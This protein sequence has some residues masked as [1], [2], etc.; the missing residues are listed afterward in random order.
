MGTGTGSTVTAV[1][2]KTGG[3]TPPSTDS[4][5]VDEDVKK[6]KR[7]L[8]FP[9]GKRSNKNKENKGKWGGGRRRL[10]RLRRMFLIKFIAAIYC[11]RGDSYS[12]LLLYW[13]SPQFVLYSFKRF[14]SSLFG[15]LF[16][17]SLSCYVL[18]GFYFTFSCI[19][20]NYLVS[21]SWDY[22]RALSPGKYILRWS[23]KRS[24]YT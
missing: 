4:S 8:H 3:E 17:V 16:P 7:K 14:L 11:F 1:T 24:S 19:P 6:R 23:L 15:F 2:G 12:V 10:K 13:G 9:F 18:N 22:S 5:V 20:L 21:Y